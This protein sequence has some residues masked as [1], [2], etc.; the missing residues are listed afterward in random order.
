MKNQERRMELANFLRKKRAQISPSEVGLPPGKRRR[1][2]GLRREELAYLA[3]IGVTWYVWLEQGRVITVSAQVLKSIAKVLSLTPEEENHLFVLAQV[4]LPYVFSEV[5]PTIDPAMQQIL[6]ALETYPAY[7]SNQRWDLVAWNQA[8]CRVF[9]NF[10][11][12]ALKERNILRFVFTHPAQRQR[13]VNWEEEAQSVLALFRASCDRFV[14]ESW[15]KDLVA[16]L[17]QISPEFREWWPRHDIRAVH[18]KYKEIEHP[19]V[20][21]LLFH[22]I[23]LVSEIPSLRMV[24]EVPS[25]QTDTARKLEDLMDMD[26]I[27][28]SERNK[29]K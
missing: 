24:M 3:G 26:F 20:G 14:R 7:V 15:F 25:L 22:P 11:K 27:E 8:A 5:T 23:V 10:E 29:K 9:A 28:A 4:P 6:D 18:G 12:M 13:L 16:D 17:H 19:L 2:P 21:R 1:T